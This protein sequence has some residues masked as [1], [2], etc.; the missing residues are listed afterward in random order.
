MRKF[1]VIFSTE[2]IYKHRW[3]IVNIYRLTFHDSSK[4][5][6]IIENIY[7][8]FLPETWCNGDVWGHADD[9]GVHSWN[10]NELKLILNIIYQVFKE[11]NPRVNI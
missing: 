5:N 11:I 8:A 4:A 7:P 3:G 2:R 6:Q 10:K 1:Y 9:I